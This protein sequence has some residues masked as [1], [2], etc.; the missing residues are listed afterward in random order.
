MR[1]KMRVRFQIGRELGLPEL[2]EARVRRIG[3]NSDQ[4]SFIKK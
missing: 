4:V 3:P 2:S 1:K